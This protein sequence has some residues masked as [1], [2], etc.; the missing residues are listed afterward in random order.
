[1]RK[2]FYQVIL[3]SFICSLAVVACS[4][5][6]DSDTP[7]YR[8]DTIEYDASRKILVAYFSWGGNTQH[9][10]QTIADVTGAD[11]FPYRDCQSLSDGLQRMYCSCPRRTG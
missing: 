6:N 9:L 5:D 4:K 7:L 2:W 1:M 11:L 8:N 10:A 3:L